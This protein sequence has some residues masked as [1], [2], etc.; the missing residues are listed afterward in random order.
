MAAPLL[1]VRDLKV[2]F[3]TEDGLVKAVDGVSF[4]V[5]EGE[6]LGIVVGTLDRQPFDVG[7]LG[8]VHVRLPVGEAAQGG[9]CE[10]SGCGTTM[11]H[12]CTSARTVASHVQSMDRS[13]RAARAKVPGLGPIL[14]AIALSYVVAARRA[15]P[16]TCRAGRRPPGCE[17]LTC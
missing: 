8:S 15:M 4:S 10:Q 17:G 5:S 6:T 16:R 3:R 2:S 11:S 1:E 7:A 13:R 12:F 14:A 9:E